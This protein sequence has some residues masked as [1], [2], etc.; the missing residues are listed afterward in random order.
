[1]LGRAED[2]KALAV[3]AGLQQNFRLRLLATLGSALLSLSAILADVQ[4][5]ESEGKKPDKDKNSE[6][7]TLRVNVDL[8]TVGVRVTDRKGREVQGL[9]ADGFSIYEGDKLQKLSFF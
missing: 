5:S 2:Y 3:L 8:V 6:Q 9:T 1:M 7:Q 4:G